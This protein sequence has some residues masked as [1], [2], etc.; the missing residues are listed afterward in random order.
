MVHF[1]SFGTHKVLGSVDLTMANSY[2]ILPGIRKLE[3]KVTNT[4]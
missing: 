3:E 4:V 2:S 1:P